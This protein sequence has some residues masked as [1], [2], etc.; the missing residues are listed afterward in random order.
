M[1]ELERLSWSFKPA[2]IGFMEAGIN[3]RRFEA[4]SLV[5]GIK[6]DSDGERYRVGLGFGNSGQTLRGEASL[7]YGRQTP[8]DQ[9]LGQIDGVLVDANASWRFSAL[10]ALLVR[11][12][13]D[14][15]ETSSLASPG[16]FVRRGQAELRHAFMR[17]LIGT[18]SVGY[19]TTKYQ[20]I[21]IN[22]TLTELGLGLEYY[23][24]PEAV[25]FGRYQ[26]TSLQTTAP[27][28]GYENDEVR[29][30]MRIRQ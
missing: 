18:A 11:A 8:L 29:V 10:T 30:G 7:G 3:Q 25:L 19:A 2:F 4:A 14:V 13:T 22:E 1:R 6:R 5:D 17:P 12:S 23:L 21:L 16:G 27:A 9:R 15:V 28:G 20:G 24:A 26:H